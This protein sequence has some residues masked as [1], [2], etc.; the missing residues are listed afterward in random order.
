MSAFPET[1]RTL[2]L[3]L[4]EVADD[5]AWSEFVDLY[6]LAL[7]RYVRSRGL[8]D[9]DSWEVVQEVF[10]AVHKSIDKWSCDYTGSFRAW[11]LRVAHNISVSLVRRKTRNEVATGTSSI[12]DLLQTLPFVEPDQQDEI[13]WRRWAFFWAA[14]QVQQDVKESTWRAF[15]LTA[16]ED[17]ESSQV[18]RQLG[19]SVGA[20]YAAKCRVL[21]RIRAAIRQLD[22]ESDK[23][24]WRTES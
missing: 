24:P 20:V 23:R 11:L 16:V 22:R 3:R 19:I 9:A 21:A 10:L 15:W 5:R 18:S 2:L 12:Y 13:E 17:R 8:Q 1:R 14:G 7:Y 4:R 6:E